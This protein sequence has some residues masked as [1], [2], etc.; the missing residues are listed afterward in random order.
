MSSRIKAAIRLLK[1][2]MS[3]ESQSGAW[4]HNGGRLD[5]GLPLLREITLRRA[6]APPLP[7]RRFR[8]KPQVPQ[9][10]VQGATLTCAAGIPAV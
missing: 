1:M 8:R 9:K 2:I 4:T 5:A 3:G 7:A 10:P 6:P